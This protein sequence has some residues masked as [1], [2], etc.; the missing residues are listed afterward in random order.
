MEWLWVVLGVL[1]IVA[2]IWLGVLTLRKGHWVMFIFGLFIPLLWI[3]GA[4]IP[5]T[6]SARARGA[7]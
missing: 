3:I 4:L 7:Y 2:L 5:P 1:Y 6:E